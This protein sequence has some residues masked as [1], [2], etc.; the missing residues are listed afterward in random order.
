MFNN[1][2]L[3]TCFERNMRLFRPESYTVASDRLVEGNVLARET[4]KTFCNTFQFFFT[5]IADF[6]TGELLQQTAPK[7]FDVKRVVAVNV[8]LQ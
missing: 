1:I 7:N 8:S 2:H 4:S 6:I 3:S 5:S